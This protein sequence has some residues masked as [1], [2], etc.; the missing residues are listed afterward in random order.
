[1][2]TNR[3]EIVRE[4]DQL[5]FHLR[6]VEGMTLLNGL[7]ESSK[8]MLQNE[9]LHLRRALREPSQVVRHQGSDG[10]H[11]IVV[12][13]QDGSVL[14]KSPHVP[15]AAALD[16]VVERVLAVAPS[17]PIVDLSKRAAVPH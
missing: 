5:T 6:T 14:A 16:E 17:A 10:S 11:W 3:F 2:P 9:I 4:R 1:M 15:S 12:K 13:D 7:A 8:I